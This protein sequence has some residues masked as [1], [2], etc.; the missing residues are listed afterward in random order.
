[1]EGQA[2][3]LLAHRLKKLANAAAQGTD[4][5]ESVKELL[6]RERVLRSEQ[7]S[8]AD[9]SADEAIGFLRVL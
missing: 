4:I 7:S 5:S 8:M 1:M 3:S 2:T 9:D 6:M